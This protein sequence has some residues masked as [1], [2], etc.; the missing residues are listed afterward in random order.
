MGRFAHAVAVEVAHITQ[1]GF[2]QQRVFSRIP[3]AEYAGAL[4]KTRRT[5]K[6]KMINSFCPVQR[7]RTIPLH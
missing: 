5:L 7:S 6:Q 1:R 4:R 3:M 2:D